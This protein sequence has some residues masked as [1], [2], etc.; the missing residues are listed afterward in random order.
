MSVDVGLFKQVMRR[1]ATG[2]MVLTVRNGGEMH[3]MTANAV[4]SVSLNPL[5]MLVCIEKSAHSHELVHAAGAFALNI[6]SERQ[7]ELGERF[8]YD[9][10]ARSH[11]ESLVEGYAGQTGALILQDSLGF[12][13][14][15]VT[16]EYRAGDHTIFIGQVVNAQ[17]NETASG[18]LLYYGGRWPS[19]KGP[20]PG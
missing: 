1:F 13:E 20:E 14:C 2:V 5:L 6:L 7:R 17:L 8:A 18:P 10:E 15:R 11:P 16:A 12:L 3:A 9:R 4:T 19:L